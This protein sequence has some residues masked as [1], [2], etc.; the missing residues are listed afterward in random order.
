[1]HWGCEALDRIAH[2]RQSGEQIAIRDVARIASS[3]LATLSS[4]LL[5]PTAYWSTEATVEVDAEGEKS[6]LYFGAANDHP[7][8]LSC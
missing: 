5:K 1:M 6:C 4:L 8:D 7:R 3:S 2:H